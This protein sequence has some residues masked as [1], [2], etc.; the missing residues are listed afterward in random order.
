[1]STEQIIRNLRGILNGSANLTMD[2]YAT[3]CAAIRALG[4]NP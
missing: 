2:E 4:G 3:I 1:M